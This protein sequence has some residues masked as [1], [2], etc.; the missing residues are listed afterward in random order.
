MKFI[1]PSSADGLVDELVM[2]LHAMAAGIGVTYQGMT[3][4]L[5]QVNYSSYR[6]GRISFDRLVE[7]I[8]W[9]SMVPMLLRPVWRR[10]VDAAAL[11]DR[12]FREAYDVEWTPPKR[13]SIEPDRDAKSDLAEVRAG[14]TTL[15]EV[16]R[17]RGYD[18]ETVFAE[19]AATNKTLDDL[20][21][22]LDSDPRKVTQQGLA[23]TEPTDGEE[24]EPP[25]PT[26]QEQRFSRLR[27]E[28]DP[29]TGRVTGLVG[30]IK[31]VA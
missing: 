22:V 27:V 10:F 3:G 21:I 23:Q 25:K 15:P 18:P 20:G 26:K 11:L 17:G 2:E 14:L 7:S 29:K 5:R 28:R 1:D 4:D 24:P 6:A 13:V 12:G 8:Q 9:K 31:E 19:I 30:E 16:I